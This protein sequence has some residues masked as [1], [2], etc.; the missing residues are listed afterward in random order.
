ML[1]QWEGEQILPLLST[2]HCC[3][4]PHWFFFFCCRDALEQLWIVTVIRSFS[5][6]QLSELWYHNHNPHHPDPPP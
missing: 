5:L 1:I 3:F 2:T 6:Q 4:F